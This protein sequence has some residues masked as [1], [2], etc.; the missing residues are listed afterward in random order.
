MLLTC[1]VA[2]YHRDLLADKVLMA[3]HRG[4]LGVVVGAEGECFQFIDFDTYIILLSMWTHCLRTPHG[5]GIF[6][7]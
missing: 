5:L 1:Q 6:V 4:R 7:R 3:A 2:V